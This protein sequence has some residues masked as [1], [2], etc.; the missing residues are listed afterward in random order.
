MKVPASNQEYF[1]KKALLYKCLLTSLCDHKARITASWR[2]LFEH[3]VEPVQGRAVADPF[4]VEAQG[5]SASYFASVVR[6]PVVGL[7]CQ[8]AEFQ[9]QPFDLQEM[10]YLAQL[11]FA[12]VLLLQ[13]PAGPTAF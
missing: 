7:Q 3:P 10:R 5:L 9:C 2:L 8:L 12:F 4:V 11:P 1:V 13:K 6:H